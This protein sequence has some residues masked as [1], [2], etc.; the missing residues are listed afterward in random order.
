MTT[1]IT[2][3]PSSARSLAEGERSAKPYTSSGWE[4]DSW[5]QPPVSYYV[6]YVDGTAFR[7]REIGE[8]YLASLSDVAEDQDVLLDEELKLWQM[9]GQRLWIGAEAELDRE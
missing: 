1:T 5:A 3:A 9:A 7:G 4:S 8:F 2:P 6:L